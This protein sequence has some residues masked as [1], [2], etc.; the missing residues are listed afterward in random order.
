M[1]GPLQALE[2]GCL[3]LIVY[4][5]LVVAKPYWWAREH[6]HQV[7]RALVIALVVAALAVLGFCYVTSAASP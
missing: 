1:D 3:R 4:A 2:G 6:W 7:R 5:S